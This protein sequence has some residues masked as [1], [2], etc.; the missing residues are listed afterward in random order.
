M[1]ILC[2]ALDPSANVHLADILSNIEEYELSGVFSPTLGNPLYSNEDFAVMGFV[3]VISKL[4]RAREAIKEVAFLSRDADV[5]ILIDAPS[6]NMPLAKEIKKQNPN[7][8]IIY[9]IL[10]KVWIWKKYRAK[11]IEKYI[12]EI[13]AI[14]PFEHKYYPTSKYFGNPL[15]NQIKKFKEHTT[16]IKKIAFFPGSRNSEIKKHMPVFLELSNL[17]KEYELLLSIP[18]HFSDEKIAS[19]Y[20]DIS[21]FKIYKDS[22]EC[23]Y[24]AD[25]AYVCSGTA[26]LEVSLIGTPFVLVYIAKALDYFIASRVVDTK[27]VGLANIIFSYADKGLFHQELIQDDVTIPNLLDAMQKIDKEEFLKNSIDIRE[28]LKGDVSKEVARIIQSS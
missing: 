12:D 17:L 3:D 2:S 19:L 23:A 20:G 25:F 7:I 18:K 10:P 4:F 11:I 22:H 26:T 15:Y 16:V 5:V 13:I 8:K 14:F 27:Y 24:D 1:K 6:F 21:R 9:Y 28:M